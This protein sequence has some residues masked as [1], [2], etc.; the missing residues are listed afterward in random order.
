MSSLDEMITSGFKS[1]FKETFET[2]DGQYLESKTSLLE[3]LEEI[4]SEEASKRTCGGKETLAGHVYHTIFYIRVLK[5]YI[6][7]LI[8]DDIDWDESW[9]ITDVSGKEWDDL[10]KE[11]GKEYHSLIKYIQSINDWSNEDLFSGVL[12]ILA[13]CA[14]HLGAVR[15]NLK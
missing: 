8:S 6:A 15:Q 3:T 10:K 11:L 5:D 9:I 13:H 7:G 1:I 4:S 12:A 2:S 14:Y